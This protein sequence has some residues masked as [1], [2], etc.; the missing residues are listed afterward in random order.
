MTTDNLPALRASAALVPVTTTTT[1]VT[2]ANT[3][4]VPAWRL[5]AALLATTIITGSFGLLTLLSGWTAPG[6]TVLGVAVLLLAAFGFTLTGRP[7][8]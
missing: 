8:P 6:Y 1:P 3:A 7:R 2:S 4:A 5:P